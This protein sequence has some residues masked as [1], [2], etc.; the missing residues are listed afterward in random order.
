[1]TVGFFI[2]ILLREEEKMGY[3]GRDVEVVW[4]GE[5]LFPGGLPGEERQD[6]RQERQDR[7][8]ERCLI[9]ACDSS[10]A[11]GAKELDVVK[12]PAQL[13][14]RF[15]IRVALLEV[16][17]VGGRPQALTVAICG[18]PQPTGEGIL[19]GI[20]EELALVGLQHLPIAISTEKNMPTRQTGLGVGVT[21]T[22]SRD[23]LR[24]GR[25]RAGDWLY[26][27]GL[28][29]VGAEVESPE[30]PEIIQPGD[31]AVLL[32]LPWVQDL[33]PVGSQGIRREAASLAQEVG[34]RLELVSC[35][36]DLEKSAGPSTCLLFTA[37]SELSAREIEQTIRTNVRSD[38]PL[39]CLGRI[40]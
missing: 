28:P 1:M 35:S 5:T 2:F 23:T 27:L 36:V 18:E 4:L 38:L 9:I 34:C 40:V 13:V 19:Q 6:R 11:I 37:P 32:G 25:S 22:A 21:A 30:D 15:T 20:R 8:Q 10:A 7:R 29:K 31:V 12:V 39:T 3:K 33:L 24:L 16:L 14:G 26:C 17:A